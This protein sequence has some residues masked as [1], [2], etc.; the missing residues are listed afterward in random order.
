[1][2]ALNPA[3]ILREPKNQLMFKFD[4]KRFNDV[5]TGQFEEYQ[6]QCYNQSIFR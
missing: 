2:A 6:H 3:A 1:M 5:V 4:M